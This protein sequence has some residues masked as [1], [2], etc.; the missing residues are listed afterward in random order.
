[1]QNDRAKFKNINFSTYALKSAT[2][3]K[4]WLGLLREENEAFLHFE[5]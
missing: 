1:M 3:C 2:E 5:L 4:F